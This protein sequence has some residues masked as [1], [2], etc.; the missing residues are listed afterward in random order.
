MAEEIKISVTCPHCKENTGL[1]KVER[2]TGHV[3]EL[4]ELSKKEVTAFRFHEG[5]HMHCESC[6]R[7]LDVGI[8]SDDKGGQKILAISCAY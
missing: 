2:A 3:V 7:A 5:A 1:T 8:Y 4:G 6:G